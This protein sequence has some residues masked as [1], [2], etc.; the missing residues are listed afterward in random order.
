M[1]RVVLDAGALLGWFDAD[2]PHRSLRAAYEAGTLTV[3]GPRTIVAEALG[4]LAEQGVTPDVLAL[5]GA[6]LQRIGLHVQDPP[7]DGL[8]M[9]LGKGLAPHRAAYAA[10]AASLEVPL[11]TDDPD[12]RRVA[13]TVLER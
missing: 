1:R 12:L 4:A 11:V 5:V 2:G 13:A 10:L 7:V 6:E 8:A 9:W 3:I